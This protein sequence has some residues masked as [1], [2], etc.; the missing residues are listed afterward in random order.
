[1]GP[2]VEH[3][4]SFTCCENGPDWRRSMI[5]WGWGYRFA[6]VGLHAVLFEPD[7][8]ESERARRMAHR[9][10]LHAPVRHGG[11]VGHWAQQHRQRH[12]QPPSRLPQVLLD[13][14]HAARPVALL[15]HPVSASA[16][17]RHNADRLQRLWWLHH[18]RSISSSGCCWPNALLPPSDDR[19]LGSGC[20]FR[21]GDAS[22]RAAL[23]QKRPTNYV[24]WPLTICSVDISTRWWYGKEKLKKQLKLNCTL[25]HCRHVS[26]F[27]SINPASLQSAFLVPSRFLFIHPMTI[28]FGIRTKLLQ[29][30]CVV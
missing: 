2:S 28:L 6:G 5:G 9:L 7:G 16:L 30:L 25:R 12:A 14:P 24:L 13:E 3:Q 26:F 22:V 8:G 23:E 27:L 10:Q 17:L 21:V 18:P 19:P 1:M 15:R 20:R 4:T 11:R 29:I